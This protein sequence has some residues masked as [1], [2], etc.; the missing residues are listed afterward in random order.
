MLRIGV[1]FMPGRFVCVRDTLLNLPR[2]IPVPSVR[3]ECMTADCI[4]NNVSSCIRYLCSGSEIKQ[5]LESPQ[6]KPESQATPLSR[7]FEQCGT[8]SQS[9]GTAPTKPTTEAGHKTS[10]ALRSDEVN[11]GAN[12]GDSR[13]RYKFR[14]LSNTA[15]SCY[16]NSLMQALA[17]VSLRGYDLGSFQKTLEIISDPADSRPL[18]AV[19]STMWLNFSVTYSRTQWDQRSQST[20]KVL[21]E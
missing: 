10:Q 4:R 9:S 21:T 20:G 15:N 16:A 19:G 2:T 1:C 5:Y 14:V 6:P 18:R 13:R 3:C 12:H 7:S 17:A 11:Q 8:A